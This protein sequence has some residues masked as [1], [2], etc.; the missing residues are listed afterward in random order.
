[1]SSNR[2]IYDDCAFSDFL[3]QNNDQFNHRL[4]SGYHFNCS[5]C[6]PKY[7]PG[8]DY[9]DSMV[10]NSEVIKYKPELDDEWNIDVES[11]LRN[12]KIKNSKAFD[13]GV[14]LLNMNKLTYDAKKSCNILFDPLTHVYT[15]LTYPAFD[16]KVWYVNRF[17]YLYKDP[18][19]PSTIYWD[20]GLDTKQY[21][22]DTYRVDGPIPWDMKAG[23]PN[24]GATT[25][26]ASA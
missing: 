14:N 17:D 5:R 8:G 6:R 2:L 4:W 9:G 13:G 21:A 25:A 26:K 18:Q 10:N 22:K 11:D 16:V 20:R 1:M 19:D 7:S 24:M 15:R 3:R 23:A 12:L